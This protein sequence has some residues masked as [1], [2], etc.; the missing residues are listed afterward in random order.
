MSE[1][2]A[3]NISAVRFYLPCPFL[4]KKPSPVL[5]DTRYNVV[6]PTYVHTKYITYTLRI[7]AVRELRQI[8]HR[9]DSS[10]DNKNENK[11]GKKKKNARTM[12]KTSWRC[13]RLKVGNSKLPFKLVRI[14]VHVPVLSSSFSFFFSSF[15]HTLERIIVYVWT[16][17]CG[18]NC[19][20]KLTW[21]NEWPN[22]KKKKKKKRMRTYTLLLSSKH[23]RTGEP[24]FCL[25]LVNIRNIRRLNYRPKWN[26]IDV[27]TNRFVFNSNTNAK[28]SI[29]IPT[30]N[31][32]ARSRLQ[33]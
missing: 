15:V 32:D 28:F 8:N 21:S 9:D 18:D 30:I 16:M 6:V 17:K 5:V 33:L 20:V 29:A 23:K 26:V 19:R 2:L 14:H 24:I 1:K 31:V 3:R 11:T 10:L 13:V 25:F 4:R 12:R 7:N 27:F 22:W